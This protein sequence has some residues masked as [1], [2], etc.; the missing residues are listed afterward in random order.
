MRSLEASPS[1]ATANGPCRRLS[2]PIPKR[3]SPPTR[4]DFHRENLCMHS[5]HKYSC[6][7]S[8]SHFSDASTVDDAEEGPPGVPLAQ[9]PYSVSDIMS[10]FPLD[11]L[12]GTGSQSFVYACH[13]L[14][15]FEGIGGEASPLDVPLCI[16]H[17]VADAS[18]EALTAA[19][20]LIH[21]HVARHFAVLDDWRG[22]WI[23]MEYVKGPDLAVYVHRRGRLGVSTAKHIFR[24]L[25]SALDCVHSSGL[26]HQD[27]KLENIV[28]RHSSGL[29][30]EQQPHHLR[31]EK[32]TQEIREPCQRGA[33]SDSEELPE[34]KSPPAS[35]PYLEEEKVKDCV[36]LEILLVD[37]GSAE[38]V[39]PQ[40]RLNNIRPE[41]SPAG[42]AMYICCLVAIAELSGASSG[43]P[44]TF[45]DAPACC[46]SDIWSAGILLCLLLVG[47][48][49]F[50]GSS[51]LSTLAA[52]A[53]CKSLCSC[54]D[55]ERASSLRDARDT[56]ALG[57]G[58]VFARDLPGRKRR[59]QDEAKSMPGQ[60][61]AG[62][63]S[64]CVASEGG[65]GGPH[66][67]PSRLPPGTAGSDAVLQRLKRVFSDPEWMGVP[68]EAKA[69]IAR[70]LAVDAR[71]LDALRSSL[72]LAFREKAHLLFRAALARVDRENAASAKL[73]GREEEASETASPLSPL[74]PR[75]SGERA[76]SV[77]EALLA[78][79]EEGA[80][81][82][83]LRGSSPV[84][85]GR[86]AQF[87][88]IRCADIHSKKRERAFREFVTT[89]RV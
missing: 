58:D 35:P 30:H 28:V 42:T 3:I 21:P 50:E 46:K 19:C 11:R 47:K 82:A 39:C 59:P 87:S 85:V 70:M 15:D 41:G 65:K 26:V 84:Q 32:H 78:S 86:S 71:Q 75:S 44:E 54:S 83:V 29:E 33:L 48:S 27:V 49:P 73:G 20:R 6:G 56:H 5:A 13:S 69:L 89:S 17:I 52:A 2:L 68:S 67:G 88:C 40:S 66:R 62:S 77:V 7:V 53:D 4:G 1:E 81:I 23:L 80:K 8:P 36:P 16:K 25:I 43:A 74:P 51:V 24:Q 63:L 72:R 14:Q 55:A 9:Q 38:L 60:A 31:Q 76:V 18:R 22:L 79:Q 57:V 12:I 37:F 34:N 61:A 45:T 64:S 10:L